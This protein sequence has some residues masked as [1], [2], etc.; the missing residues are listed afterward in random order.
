MNKAKYPPFRPLVSRAEL[1]RSAG[2]RSG[3]G[4]GAVRAQAGG[5]RLRPSRPLGV[6]GFP[7]H[8]RHRGVAEPIAQIG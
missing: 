7:G 6:H 5:T 3:G 8:Y 2:H 1:D 4:V